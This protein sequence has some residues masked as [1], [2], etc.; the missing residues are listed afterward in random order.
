M[1]ICLATIGMAA[2]SATS[3]RYKGIGAEPGGGGAG[4]GGEPAAAI[5]PVC[6]VLS[7]GVPVGELGEVA[8]GAPGDVPAGAPGAVPVGAPG[9]VPAGVPGVVGPDGVPGCV[10]GTTGAGATVLRKYQLSLVPAV[11]PPFAR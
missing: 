4:K 3:G 10:G 5:G 1:P 7:G 9:D 6:A 2:Y 11:T 8:V